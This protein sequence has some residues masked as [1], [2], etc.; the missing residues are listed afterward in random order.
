MKDEY[1]YICYWSKKI[2]AIKHLGGKCKICGNDNIF[3]LCFHHIN[4]TEKEFNINKIKGHRWSILSKEINKCDLLCQNC[5]QEL[6]FNESTNENDHR[7]NKKIYLEY[8]GQCCEKCGYNKCA[9]ALS[10]HHKN[11][12]KK[13]FRISTYTK[14]LFDLNDYIKEELDKCQVLCQNCHSEEHINNEKFEK[15]KE[16]IY[17]HVN[18]PKE[19]QSK[20]DRN[21]VYEMYNSGIKQIDIAKHFNASKGTIC[22]IIKNKKSQ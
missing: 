18:N 7:N 15:L 16:Q 9:G 17:E 11:P 1:S 12:D 10:F 13:L 22:G 5:H 19:K 2:R 20:L 14:T 4:T 21:I 3:Q 6:H 8:K